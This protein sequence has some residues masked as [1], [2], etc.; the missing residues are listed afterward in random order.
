[1][2]EFSYFP[3]PRPLSTRIRSIF[4]QWFIEIRRR[5]FVRD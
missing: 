3:S 4:L 1:M 5:G 2:A